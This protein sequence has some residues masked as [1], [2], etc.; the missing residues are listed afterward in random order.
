V[1]ARFPRLGQRRGQL[2]GTLSGGEQQ[3]LAMARVLA[4]DPTVLLL[5]E[6]SMGLAPLVVAELY[7]L[8]AA[9]AE[10]GLAILVVEQFAHTALKV[11]DH[12]VVMTNGQVVLSGAPADVEARL[13]AAYLGGAA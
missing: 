8:V 10:Q 13:S 9:L 6:I 1:Y 7:E 11:A 2:A 5:D 4:V 12:A 3:M